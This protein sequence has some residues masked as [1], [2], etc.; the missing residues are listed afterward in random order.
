MDSLEKLKYLVVADAICGGGLYVQ[1][2]QSIT[3]DQLDGHVTQLLAAGAIEA[4]VPT[5]S[6]EQSSKDRS[7][8]L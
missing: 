5:E 2:G 1:K 6:P 7:S 4:L 8:L 3:G